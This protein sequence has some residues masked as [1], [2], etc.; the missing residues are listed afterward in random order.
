MTWFKCIK[1]FIGVSPNYDIPVGA[2]EDKDEEDAEDVD[3][4]TLDDE[5][6][7][8]GG[9]S[10][11]K[12]KGRYLVFWFGVFVWLGIP[13]SWFFSGEVFL[14]EGNVDIPTS[15]EVSDPVELEHFCSFS[16]MI[17]SLT[18]LRNTI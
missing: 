2:S 8:D 15:S 14:L 18:T 13:P 3:V 11:F 7:G 16:F 17:N 12:F 10:I 5:D 4:W 6:E 9:A 1:W